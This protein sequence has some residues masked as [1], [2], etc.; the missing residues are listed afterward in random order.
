MSS[1]KTLYII[2]P[3]KKTSGY[4]LT[5]KYKHYTATPTKFY[6][7][8]LVLLTRKSVKHIFQNNI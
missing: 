1:L 2:I 3:A 8:L 4:Q 7:K 5:T 6:F